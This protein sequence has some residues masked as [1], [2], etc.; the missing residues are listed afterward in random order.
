MPGRAATLAAIDIDALVRALD[1]RGLTTTEVVHLVEAVD[2]LLNAGILTDLTAIQTDSLLQLIGRASRPQLAAVVARPD[3][4]AMALGEFVARIPGRFRAERANGLAAVLHIRLSD[5]EAIQL[6]IERGTCRA[7]T[8][9]DR[10]PDVMITA[11]PV[12]LLKA[13]T[14]KLTATGLLLSRRISARGDLRL[15]LRTVLAFDS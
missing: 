4:R 8:E 10:E 3:L 12:D 15:A 9:L 14:S 7:G 11:D 2:I 13:T 1:P 6:A 5:A